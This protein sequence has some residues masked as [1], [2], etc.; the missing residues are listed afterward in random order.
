MTGGRLQEGA[1]AFD[2]PGELLNNR[3]PFAML[4][5]EEE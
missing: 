2:S 5:A 3:E 4:H 1:N